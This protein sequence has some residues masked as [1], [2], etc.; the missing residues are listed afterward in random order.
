MLQQTHLNT[1]KKKRKHWKKISYLVFNI[2]SFECIREITQ[3]SKLGFNSKT[4]HKEVKHVK[5]Q[6]VVKRCYLC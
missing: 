1:T 4:I 3:L 6:R 5:N 2:K